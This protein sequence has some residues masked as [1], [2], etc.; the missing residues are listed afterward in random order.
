MSASGKSSNRRYEYS[1]G[2]YGGGHGIYAAQGRQD[3]EIQR[4][5]DN[6]KPV[7]PEGDDP[8]AGTEITSILNFRLFFR[9][10]RNND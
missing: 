7:K 6:Q 1:R 10:R 8:R 4:G 5:N 2:Y 9:W 3:A